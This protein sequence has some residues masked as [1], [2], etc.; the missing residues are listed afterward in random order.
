MEN[1]EQKQAVKQPAKDLL[2]KVQATKALVTA[3]SLLGVGMFQ[4][5]HSEAL[6]QSIDF[7]QALHSQLLEECLAHP[8]ADLIQELVDYKQEAEKQAKTKVQE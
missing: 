6:K 3:H 7:L 8:D 1:N 5:R 4:H 2:D